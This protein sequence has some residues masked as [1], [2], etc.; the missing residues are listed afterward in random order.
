MMLEEE[1][2][3]DCGTDE[4]KKNGYICGCFKAPKSIV[5]TNQHFL[6]SQQR[7][8]VLRMHVNMNKNITYVL[9]VVSISQITSIEFMS[10]KNFVKNLK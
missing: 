10:C 9:C 7:S 5:K 4:R 8:I 1:K 6:G 3:R 2:E